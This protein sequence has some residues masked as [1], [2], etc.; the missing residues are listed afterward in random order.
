MKRK[1]FRNR[2]EKI[3]TCLREN[4]VFLATQSSFNKDV[5]KL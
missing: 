3:E 4:H 1:I 2:N 5:L